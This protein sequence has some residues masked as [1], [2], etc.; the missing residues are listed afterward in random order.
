[1][2]RSSAPLTDNKKL[3]IINLY[4][5]FSGDNSRKEDHQKL[6][7]HKQVTEV[8]GVAER[9]VAS[10]VSDWNKRGDDTFT[11]HKTLGR[12]KSKPDENILELLRTKILDANKK[13]EQLSTPI[14]QLNMDMNF[15]NGSFF[16]Y[17]TIWVIILAKENVEIFFTK[18]NNEVP[19]CP[20][21]FLD[22]SY[23]HLHHTSRNTW[24]PHQG[25]ILA[26]GHGPLV[27][28]FGAIIVF[29]NG[30]S[31]K[32]HGELVPNSV[33]IWDPTI[34]P[35]ENR[36]RKRNNAEEWN[37]VPNI[38]KDSNIVPNQVDYHGNFNAEI[39]EDLF[40]TLCQ[41]LHEKYGPVNI[42]M[43]GANYHKRRVET[44]PSSSSKKQE[45][46]EWLNAHDIPFS[47]NLKRPE[48]LELVRINK[49]KV[50][51]ACVKIA[52]QYEH[53]LSFTPPYH[54]EL[55]P[56]EGVWVVVKGEVACS[57]PHPNLLSVR[58][59]L[60]EAFKR[61]ITSQVILGLW[62][63]ALKNAK[64]YFKSDEDAQLI[65][66]EFNDDSDSD[67]DHVI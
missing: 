11:P 21:V 54:C 8:L 65:D 4:N 48:L 35:P 38:V 61:K 64:E 33:H 18:G 52:E 51:F 40:S 9:T 20:E 28:I 17:F 45:L 37:D 56:I 53:E 41:T 59:T 50:P 19:S 25:V 13:A 27:V 23:C 26:P 49:E 60:L 14:L 31:N 3:M 62:R 12:P 36:G 66:D 5:Y 15:L 44:I 7:L 2:K 29:R 30:S 16:G 1:M 32:L 58:N 63:R 43:D 47:S 10:V 39:F 42:H 57:S 24:V 67:E 55:Q 34:K 46:I 6:T 22:E